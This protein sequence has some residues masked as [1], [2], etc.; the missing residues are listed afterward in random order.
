MDY[1][2][3]IFEI[4]P[5]AA[6]QVAAT[7]VLLVGAL[8]RYVPDTIAGKNSSA[9]LGLVLS[10]VLGAGGHLAPFEGLVL[11][12]YVGA[13]LAGLTVW[14]IATGSYD[15]LNGLVGKVGGALSGAK[16]LA[17]KA[18]EEFPEEIPR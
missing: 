10:F 18:G 6:A 13:I 9:V 4:D 8:K 12:N 16:A 2:F 3:T 11:M 15:T 14:A 5:V 1:L 7:V 17:L